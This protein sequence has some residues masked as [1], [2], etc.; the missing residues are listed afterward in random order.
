MT[1]NLL[2]YLKLLFHIYLYF[3]PTLHTYGVIYLRSLVLHLLFLLVAD[4]SKAKISQNSGAT[5]ANI[6]HT[7][8]T[9][10][11]VILLSLTR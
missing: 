11:A 3:L 9:T 7:V 1:D 2:F 4:V 10:D 8:L 6:S 5:N